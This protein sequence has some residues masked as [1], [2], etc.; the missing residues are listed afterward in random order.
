VLIV[1]TVDAQVFPVGAVW[2]IVPGV[3]VPVMDGEK[4]G[5]PRVEFTTA[6]RANQTVN[7][8]GLFPVAALARLSCFPNDFIDGLAHFRRA[9]PCSPDHVVTPLS[10]LA[11]L[12]V[13]CPNETIN[14][15][16]CSL[17]HFL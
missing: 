7:S 9:L 17:I 6:F 11:P 12:A 4:M 15:P 16:L 13:Y 5:V 2:R 14:S 1:M 8:Q 10:H 3:A